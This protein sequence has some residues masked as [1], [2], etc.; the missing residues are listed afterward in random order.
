MIM[1]F[2]YIYSNILLVFLQDNINKKWVYFD[3]QNK[4]YEIQQITIVL[5]Q[6]IDVKK[7]ALT[8]LN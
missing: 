2:L 1:L 7:S 4:V 6:G 3:I 8:N 5:F